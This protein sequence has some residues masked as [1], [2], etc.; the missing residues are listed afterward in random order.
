MHGSFQ[1]YL[2]GA[3]PAAYWSGSII[4]MSEE[5]EAGKGLKIF[6]YCLKV[7]FVLFVLFVILFY[8]PFAQYA[9]VWQTLIRG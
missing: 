4:K 9:F 1:V 8:G 6:S 5:K 3:L 7:L 2:A